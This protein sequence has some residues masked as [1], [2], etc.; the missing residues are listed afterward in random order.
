MDEELLGFV[1]SSG[2]RRRVLRSLESHGE[3][4]LE[5]IAS[6]EHLPKPTVQKVL[7]EAEERELVE[8]E[9]DEYGLTER[10]ARLVSRMGELES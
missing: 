2:R 6:L 9:G 4:S 7:E 10:G 8:V 1:A 5:R 3:M